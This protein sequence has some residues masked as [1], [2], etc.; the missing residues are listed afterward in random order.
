ERVLELYSGAGL[1]TVP[2]AE[3]VG[4]RG[5]VSALEGARAAVED[6]RAN[7]SRHPQA[8]V[9]VAR[10][11]GRRVAAHRGA[12]DVVVLDPPRSGAGGAVTAA[13]LEK[14][15]A[16]IVYVACDPAALARDLK[17]LVG[18]YAVETVQAFDLFPSTHHMEMVV[19]LVRR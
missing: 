18:A 13:L 12:I 1:F 19:G 16:R 10:V 11:D 7:L 9:E 17:A 3:A 2:L 8:R 6:A 15:P 14:A 5:R 4:P